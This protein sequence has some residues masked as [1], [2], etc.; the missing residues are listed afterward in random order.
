[1]N[2]DFFFKEFPDGSVHLESVTCPGIH[3]GVVKKENKRDG[4][5]DSLITIIKV[6]RRPS[7]FNYT[8]HI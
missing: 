5:V 2:G 6:V 3:I 4:A 7:C 8:Y 1:M